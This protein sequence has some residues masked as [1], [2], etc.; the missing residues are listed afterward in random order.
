[1]PEVKLSDDFTP[2]TYNH[3]ELT[4]RLAKVFQICFGETNV[5]KRKP[6]MGG[7][8]FAEYGRTEHKIPICMFVVGGVS[9]EALKKSE[10]N[11]Q[12]LPSLHSPFWAPDA[13]PTI[14][15][16]I[17]AMVL[18]VLDLMGTK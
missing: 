3:P 17:T 14:K 15:T 11:G 13:G 9:L 5:I 2:A 16:G 7:E 12:S 4:E 10:E 8:D 6:T 18:A 1:M